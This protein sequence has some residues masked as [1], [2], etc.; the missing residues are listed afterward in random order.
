MRV[1]WLTLVKFTLVTVRPGSKGRSGSRRALRPLHLSWWE[2]IVERWLG[3]KAQVGY[4]IS[5]LTISILIAAPLEGERNRGS[6]LHGQE[7]A[8]NCNL[9]LNLRMCTLSWPQLSCL[10]RQ[11]CLCLVRHGARL[12]AENNHC[13]PLYEFARVARAP[14]AK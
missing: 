7:A 13:E 4:T 6:E 8:K 11:S 14:I 2:L 10:R 3:L 5:V 1:I 9:G 12:L